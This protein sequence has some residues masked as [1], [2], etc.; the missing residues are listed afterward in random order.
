MLQILERSQEAMQDHAAETT[1]SNS[2]GL[3]HLLLNSYQEHLIQNRLQEE[4]EREDGAQ[5]EDEDE[6]DEDSTT[7]FWVKPSCHCASMNNSASAC[8]VAGEPAQRKEEEP[9]A[10][11]KALL[12]EEFVSQMYQH[13]LDG[14]DGDFNY[15]WVPIT[16]I[17][18]RMNTELCFVDRWIF[19]I[20][21][22]SVI[23]FVLNIHR[24]V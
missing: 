6:E 17:L 23:S 14:K 2:A 20:L 7:R 10:E 12:R 3:A 15:R 19:C 4:Q 21:N 22:F 8:S 16:P 18:S 13:F 11:E 1:G 5:E 9:T 24:T